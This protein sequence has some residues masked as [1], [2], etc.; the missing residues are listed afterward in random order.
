MSDTQMNELSQYMESSEATSGSSMSDIVMRLVM[1]TNATSGADST[2]IG[3]GANSDSTT[4]A[5]PNVKMSSTTAQDVLNTLNNALAPN[6][7]N[8]NAM[9]NTMNRLNSTIK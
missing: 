7:R 1:N 6:I 9:I 8:S 5:V 3:L 4:F 2:K